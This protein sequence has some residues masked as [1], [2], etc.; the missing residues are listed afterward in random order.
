LDLPLVQSGPTLLQNLERASKTFTQGE[1]PMKTFTQG[2]SPLAKPLLSPRLELLLSPY[3]AK[4]QVVVVADLSD[5]HVNSEMWGDHQLWCERAFLEAARARETHIH[6]NISILSEH[7]LWSEW[8]PRELAELSECEEQV[9]SFTQMNEHESSSQALGDACARIFDGE[10]I[11]KKVEGDMD[12]LLKEMSVPWMLR[13]AA[14]SLG[15][16]VGTA[17]VRIAQSEDDIK[18]TTIT[19]VKTLTRVLKLHGCE[20]HEEIEGR[21]VR[22]TAHFDNSVLVVRTHETATGKA[23]PLARRFI[24]GQCMVTEQD[25]PGKKS[26]RQTYERVSST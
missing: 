17:Q 6:Y 3:V 13:K 22:T 24:D 18:M 10:W 25:L 2:E 14:A 4:P 1:S 7:Q 11:L 26:V 23:F 16:A 8:Q 15:Y 12:A 19:P 21:A 9:S 20:N 5:T